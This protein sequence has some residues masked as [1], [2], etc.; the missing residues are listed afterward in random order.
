MKKLTKKELV[1][2][3]N[4]T[5]PTIHIGKEGLT[6]GV[7]EEVKAQLKKCS[8]IKVKVLPSAEFEM[9]DAGA[10]LEAKT[11]AKCVE[12]RGFTVLLCNS[13]L[14]ERGPVT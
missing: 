11:G 14:I 8:V 6:E 5:K 7:V 12:V 10:E 1:K 13:K 2:I 3:G 4:E 9:Q